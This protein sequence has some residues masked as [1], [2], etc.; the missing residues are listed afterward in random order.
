MSIE[1][2]YNEIKGDLYE[3][4]ADKLNS[5]NA[6]ETFENYKKNCDWK[7]TFEDT[8]WITETEVNTFYEVLENDY[9]I[10]DKETIDIIQGV[11]NRAE[12]NEQLKRRILESNERIKK[13][14]QRYLL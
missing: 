9:N 6:T 10:T 8:D 13:L 2:I 4:V 7:I 5:L 11:L 3:K 1:K 14:K 12:K